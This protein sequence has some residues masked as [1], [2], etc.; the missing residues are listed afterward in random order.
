MSFAA[1]ESS[2][3]RNVEA[4]AFH[5]ISATARFFFQLES[6]GSLI[7][8]KF[9]TPIS[10]P[11]VSWEGCFTDRFLE[12]VRGQH[13]MMAFDVGNIHNT[14]RPI[15]GEFLDMLAQ[16]PFLAKGRRLWAV[17]PLN[18][19]SLDDDDHRS[20]RT[21]HGCLEWLDKQPPKSVLYVSFGTLSSLSDEQVNELAKGLERSGRRF[22][23]VLREADRG[24]IFAKE[25]EKEQ[26]AGRNRLLEGFE[27]RVRGVGVVVRDWAPQLEILAH[28]STGGFMSHCGWNSCIESIGNG[29]PMAAWP[30]H[31]DQPSNAV[32]VAEILR[33]GIVVRE[34]GRREEVVRSASVES[35]VRRLMAS[36]EGDEM[37]KRAE[38]LAV[39][40]KEAVAPRGSSMHISNRS[41]PI[42]SDSL[43]YSHMVAQT[44]FHCR[45]DAL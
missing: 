27:K 1:Q 24:D 37:R 41:S 22:I 38:E 15:E 9:K 35:A 20:S 31:S 30:M 33:V 17:G 16:E 43:P 18:P 45:S 7:S 12:F 5:C 2:T 44:G 10:L 19:M 21:R 29:V 3:H 8:G 25:E 4:Y 28:R 11:T 23:W 14:C 6:L 42:F 26:E 40:I 36:K 39:K 13:S 32:L 34:W